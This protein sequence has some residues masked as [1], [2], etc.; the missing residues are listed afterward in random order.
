MK[1]IGRHVQRTYILLEWND[2]SKTIEKQ[3]QDSI[4]SYIQTVL[5]K[6]RIP[7]PVEFH[8]SRWVTCQTATITG[9]FLF[10]TVENLK[11]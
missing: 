9:T 7:E 2:I 4:S 5:L 1:H 8:L 6:S 3:I 11:R 10:K